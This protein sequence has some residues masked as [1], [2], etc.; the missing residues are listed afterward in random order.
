MVRSARQLAA[1]EEQW[2][3]LSARFRSPLLDHDWFLSCAEAFHAD[4]EL[5]IV[6][7]LDGNELRGVAPL[8]RET[9]RLAILGSA[10][11]YEPSGW[12][13]S[14]DDVLADLVD[15]SI[16]LGDPMHLQRLPEHSPMLE[17]LSR[18]A[19]WRAVAMVRAA[20]D[21]L[22][23]N[24]QGAWADYYARLSSR[25][26]Q[27]LRRLRRKAEKVLGPMNVVRAEPTPSEVDSCLETVIAVEGSGWKGTEGSA[28]AMR[29]D[30][31]D[32]FRRYCRRAAAK[33]RLRISRLS[34]GTHVAA[35]ELSIE[36][37][38]RMWQLKIGYQ[39]SLA[40]YY[41]GLHLTEASIRGAFDRGL[42]A[43]EFLGSAADWE[44]RWRPEARRF[45]AV[46]VYPL[47][48]AGTVGA[49]RDV[50]DAGWRRW[51]AFVSRNRKAA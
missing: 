2:N 28:L 25:I 42:E 34:F 12:L 35:V 15:R 23:V 8:V 5:R 27:N 13:Y 3:A 39:D 31:Q 33:G 7:A 50:I 41:P 14:S 11:L 18:A 47:T 44:E 16:S 26:T 29:A 48:A 17:A 4:G 24:T 49:C 22:A 36:A 1:L 20:A 30:L 51:K 21:A 9:G 19:S 10:R 43:Y 38:R 37:Y 45:Q 46:A 40:A 32:F 6:T